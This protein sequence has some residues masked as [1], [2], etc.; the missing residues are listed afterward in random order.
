VTVAS[1]SFVT[2]NLTNT[3]S[4]CL[5]AGNVADLQSGSGIGGVFMTAESQG[6]SMMVGFTDK[7]GNFAC[8]SPP[9]R[10]G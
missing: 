9:M 5:L 4:T 3:P 8:P 2:K 7:D 1:N 6:G 10:G